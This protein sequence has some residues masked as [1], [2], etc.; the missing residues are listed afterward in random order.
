MVG[1]V[2]GFAGLGAGF[3]GSAIARSGVAKAARA[4]VQPSID[5]LADGPIKQGLQQ[6]LDD[7]I[8]TAEEMLAKQGEL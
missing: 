3:A 1:G 6:R 8:R 5:K 4:R 7:S 2:A